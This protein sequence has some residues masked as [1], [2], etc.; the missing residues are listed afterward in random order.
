VEVEVVQGMADKLTQEQRSENMRRIRSTDTKPELIVRRFVHA[1]G[2]RYRLHRRGLPGRPDLVF[3]SRKK[4]IF[5]HG[6]FWHA[7]DDANC[8]DR[9]T[10]KSN[11]VYWHPKLAR[12]KERDQANTTKLKLL[13]WEVLTVWEC[14]TRD[15]EKLGKI[16]AGF[17]A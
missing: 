13:G 11:V 5:V 3:A 9:R 12:N 7:H 14:D 1:M 4:I 16:L 8:P 2:Y 10:P 15:L 17:L 6:C